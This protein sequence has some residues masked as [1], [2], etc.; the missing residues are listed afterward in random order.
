M[1]KIKVDTIESSNQN[2]KLAPN[3]TGVVEVKGAGGADGTLKLVSSNGSNAVKIKS[4]AHSAG[5]S[6][7]MV[8]PD[9]QP[10]VDKYLKVK[11][12]TGSG[13]T[14]TGQLE[15]GTVPTADLTVLNAND[16]TSGT[17]PAARF[18]SSFPAT[19]GAGLK[20]ISKTTNSTSGLA[21]ISI[22]LP[23]DNARYLL[24]CK[25]LC[26][27]NNTY[28]R[29]ELL[30][31]SGNTQNFSSTWMVG[32]SEND[33]AS[34]G[35][36]NHYLYAGWS[37]EDYGFTMEITRMSGIKDSF[38]AR[39]FGIARDEMKAEVYTFLDNASQSINQIRFTPWDNTGAYARTIEPNTE[40]L[41]YQ[42]NE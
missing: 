6:Y 13:A 23:N 21:S 26:F 22:S 32:Y 7:T 33:A 39:A 42:Y 1:S 2:V 17:V 41:L 36:T 38:M 3:G 34:S 14:A 25:R 29:Y 12:I 11:S 19:S 18:P 24:Y 40:I 10:T 5:Q 9:N 35:M 15:Y 28:P 8:L 16:I 20:L 37:M 27:S 30:D 31:A 4:P